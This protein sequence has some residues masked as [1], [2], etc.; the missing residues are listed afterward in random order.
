MRAHGLTNKPI[1]S[2]LETMPLRSSL[3]FNSRTSH[4]TARWHGT[5]K[6]VAQVAPPVVRTQGYNNAFPSLAGSSATASRKVADALLVANME[7]GNMGDKLAVQHKCTASSLTIDG[8]GQA[9]ECALANSSA[10]RTPTWRLR[11]MKHALG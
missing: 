5:P 1:T 9:V 10:S 3:P 2:H 7:V 6:A 8:Q 4:S 11:T